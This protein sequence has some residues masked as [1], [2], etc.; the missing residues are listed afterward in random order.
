M[1][2][3]PMDDIEA[4]LGAAKGVTLADFFAYMPSHSYIFALT[5]AHWPA[6]SVNSRIA[7]VALVNA[8]GAPVLDEKGKQLKLAAATWLDK[9]KPVEQMTWAPGLPMVI[10]D[11]LL[12]DGG[13]IDR[14]GVNCFNLY[15]PPIIEPG[16]AS[17]AQRWVEHV[18]RVYPT[19]AEDIIDW[20]AQRVQ[21][22]EQKINHA[23]VLGGAPG[24]GKDTLL[25][26]ARYAVGPWNC[27]EVSPTQVTGR[28]NGF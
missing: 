16:D 28:F 3:D 26:P 2:G 9:N 11:R 15:Q 12:V 7:P 4:E 22:P 17:E 19:E 1:S 14:P 10:R 13:W 24:I 5:G 18:H 27:A 6:S 23:L 20:L 8:T 25:A 21:H